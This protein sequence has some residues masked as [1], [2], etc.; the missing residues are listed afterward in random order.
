MKQYIVDAFT[1]KIFSG[2]Q[3]AICV[4]DSD[5]W[6]DEDLMKNIARE[7]NFSETAFI[8]RESDRRYKL[9]WFTPGAEI[10]LCGHATLASA[11]VLLRFYER[12]SDK[13]IFD[14][15]SGELIVN[16]H[17][18]FLAMNF[19]VYDLTP[20]KVS[21]SMT[22]AIGFEPE[23]AFMGRDLMCVMKSPE[24]VINCK[25]DMNKVKT[26]EGL[27]L[28]I[29]SRGTYGADC[30]SRSFAPKIAITEDPVCGSGHCH[31]APYWSRVLNK[32]NITAYQASERGGWL[33]CSLE[34]LESERVIIS[35]KAAL[36][37]E[38]DIFT[39]QHAAMCTGSF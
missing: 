16:K 14:T 24:Q 28:H 8:M 38:A 21:D 19:P 18:D 23:A 3:A 25:P 27:L 26:L 20:V 6:P 5:S 35:G 31:I 34:S 12:D 2:N 39:S 22:Q 7:N 29:T 17:D 11:Y 30:I 10:D 32:K 15:M 4:L 36:F 37:S 9:R 1:D 13:I 33:Y